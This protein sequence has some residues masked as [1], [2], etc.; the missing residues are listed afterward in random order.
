MANQSRIEEI[1]GHIRKAQA[2]RDDAESRTE[3]HE[4]SARNARSEIQRTDHQ[5]S[6]LTTELL[7]EIKKQPAVIT[8]E[9]ITS[10]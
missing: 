7:A 10:A 4:Q 6:K 1:Q 3:F 9:R 2:F 5:I 8:K